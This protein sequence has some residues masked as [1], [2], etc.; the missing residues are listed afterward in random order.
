MDSPKER[1]ADLLPTPADEA[2]FSGVMQVRK[3][4]KVSGNILCW[5]L[6]HKWRWDSRY[7]GDTIYECS[8]WRCR[9][10]HG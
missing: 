5:F 3:Q 7:A 4:Q 8:R 6:G 9:A 2:V 10:W 1:Y